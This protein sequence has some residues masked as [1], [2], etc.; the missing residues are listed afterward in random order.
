MTDRE[1]IFDAW[2]SLSFKRSLGGRRQGI[3]WQAPTW[4]GDHARRLSAYTILQAFLDNSGRE[5]LGDTSRDA[6][7][8]HREYGDAALVRDTVVAAL[9]GEEWEIVTEGAEDFIEQVPDGAS[10]EVK[11]RSR[12]AQPAHDL[13][14][15]Y[16]VWADQE[17]FG[18]KLIETE[19]NAEGLGDGV[20]TLGWSADK[21]RVRLRV[22]DPGFYFPVLRDGNEDDFPER[23]HIAWELPSDPGTTIK[24]VRR[25]TWD[26]VDGE[27]YT[28]GYD[29]AESTTKHCLYSDAIYS[30]DSMK[31]TP[32]DFSSG[33]AEFQTDADGEINQRDLGIDFLPVVH[34]PNTVS[35]LNHFGQSVLSKVLQVLDDLANA[36]TDLS[37]AAATTGFPPV[38]LKGASLGDNEATYGPG[39]VWELPGDSSGLDV[40]DTSRSLDALL[41]YV[42]SLTERLSVNGRLPAALLGRVKPSEVPSGVALALSFGPLR[43]MIEEMRLV[44]DEK[45]PVLFRFVRRMAQAAGQADVPKGA[46]DAVTRIA[47]GSY[48]PTDRGTVVDTVTK[49][50][51]SHIISQETAVRMLVEDGGLPIDDATE[52]VQ[53]IREQDFDAAVKLL[54]ALGNEDVVWEFLNRKRP[55]QESPPPRTSPGDQGQPAN[56]PLPQA[57]GGQL[58]PAT[59]GAP[60]TQ[61]PPPPA[62]R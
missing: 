38:A 6:R 12:E 44:R 23:V 28:P 8:N 33:T 29:G 14:D 17:R 54:D 22:W 47:F 37:K 13:Q 53:R 51:T 55:P 4:V 45:Y 11:A 36:D 32:D 15:W 30:F 7:E 16:R 25:L 56:V 10:A 46:E 42:D 27:A 43:S 1:L 20:Y 2:T 3:S 26:L 31:A 41:K 58:P 21:K 57:N 62:G 40:I 18:L 24:R 52:E 49:L 39:Q 48:L 50:L 5:F 35:I 9:L 59:P 61:L 19:R 34:V 60:P